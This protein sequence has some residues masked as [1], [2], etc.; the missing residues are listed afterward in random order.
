MINLNYRD[1]RSIYEQVRDGLRRLVV[2]GAIAQGEELPPV[3][4]LAAG[5]AISP[6]AIR[7]A[8]AALEEEGYLTSRQGQGAFAAGGG[9]DGTR[10]KALLAEL[11][12]TVRE[13]LFLGVPVQELVRRVRGGQEWDRR[14]GE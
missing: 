6:T 7:R 10:Q 11:D 8:Y 14:D 13:L 1:P 5:L 9:A 4:T 12:G 3:G 2:T